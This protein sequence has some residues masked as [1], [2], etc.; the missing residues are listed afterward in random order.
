MGRT[1]VGI[2]AI[3]ALI[4]ACDDLP[5]AEN[6][7]TVIFLDQGWNEA[8]RLNYYYTPQGTQLFG[9][10]YDWLKHLEKPFSEERFASPENLRRY[11]FLVDDNPETNPDGFAV[12]FTSHVDSE[13]GARLL[14]VTCAA[15]HTG[16][17]NYGGVGIRIDGGGALHSY[18][19]FG[20]GIAK[21]LGATYAYGMKFDRFAKGVLGDTYPEGRAKLRAE[22]L[23]SIKGIGAWGYYAWRHNLYPVEEGFGRLDAVARIGNTVFA[24]ELVASNYHTGNA[25]VSLPF[26]WDIWRFDWVQYTASSQQPMARNVSEALGVRASLALIGPDG[27][28]LSADDV[29]ASSVL[30]PEMH[31][32]E[33]TLWKLTAPKWPEDILG[34][35]SRERTARGRALY[36]DMCVGCH[37]PHALPPNK[38][39][40]VGR[41]GGWRVIPISTKEIGT[42]SNAADNWVDNMFTAKPIDPSNP[43][44]KDPVDAGTGLALVAEAV[45][46][47]I[48]GE[49]GLTEQQQQEMNGFSIPND[50][51]SI[52]AYKARPLDGVWATGPYLHNGSIPNIY[53][54]LS[55]VEMR[56]K[57]FYAGSHDYD[58]VMLGYASGE[59]P[60]GFKMDTSISGN[61]N[62]GHE[63]K[64]DGK[65]L[66]IIGRELNE[67]EKW[68]LIEYLKILGE[69]AQYPMVDEPPQCDVPQAGA[70]IRGETS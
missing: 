37:G 12:G 5:E 22:V 6:P 55:P 4:T 63:F 45:T 60:G 48:Y 29:F 3:F 13:S 41:P 49:L 28:P 24:E 31:C 43:A 14:D 16:Q 17:I 2:I 42:D 11:G 23:E 61:T 56:S 27:Q 44:L 67:E 66:G 50:S 65:G 15:C 30:P 38:D 20:V 34:P 36:D 47:K 70:R 68:D 54:L 52:R 57:V 19:D 53:E 35:I 26:V 10:Q 58:P 46:N 25:P 39:V 62:A 64:G 51:Q 7:D 8:D 59:F 9:V 18:V 21:S 33:T 1:L 69:D 32:I 40:A